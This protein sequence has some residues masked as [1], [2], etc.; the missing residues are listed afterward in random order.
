MQ[1]ISAEVQALNHFHA[2]VIY[3][4]NDSPCR[5]KTLQT[6]PD[7]NLKRVSQINTNEP[8]CKPCIRF[9]WC[10]IGEI[11]E[12]AKQTAMKTA[13]NKC[14]MLSDI[15]RRNPTEISKYAQFYSNQQF[16]FSHQTPFRILLICSING[17]IAAKAKQFGGQFQIIQRKISYSSSICNCCRY[18]QRI[19]KRLFDQVGEGQV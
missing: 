8:C 13:K 1:S 14:S 7:T 6:K 19:V 11:F 9:I 2:I 18:R 5:S 16:M 15:L 4:F 3:I 10:S 12:K 17:H